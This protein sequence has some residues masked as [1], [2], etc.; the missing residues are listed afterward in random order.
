MCALVYFACHRDILGWYVGS[1]NGEF[2]ARYF[3]LDRYFDP[4]DTRFMVS[5]QDDV[6]SA[7]IT[8][9]PSFESPISGCPIPAAFLEDLGRV[10]RAFV[11]EWLFSPDDQDAAE[12]IKA[13]EARELSVQPV[14]IRVSKLAMLRTGAALW[15][16]TSPGFDR[17]VLDYL[18]EYWTLD[19]RAGFV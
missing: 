5:S 2:P 10:Q 16:Y 17:V 9:S 4:T 18:M 7:W 14:N 15:R 3:M 12:D 19:H 6:H 11:G 13:Y 8:R 1:C